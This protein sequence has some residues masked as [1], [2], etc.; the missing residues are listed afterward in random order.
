MWLLA[1][2]AFGVAQ[3]VQ[4]PSIPTA[5]PLDGG[6]QPY[7]TLPDSSPDP[8]LRRAMEEA[9]RKRNIERQAKMAAE[10]DR[11]C[12]LAQELIDELN[13][14]GSHPL[15][16]ASVKKMDEIQKLAKSVKDR[17]RSE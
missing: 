17:M 5:P 6:R 14:N 11:I 7:G 9:A 13:K 16:V 12:A 4:P 3:V 10:S 15:P 1:G 8:A 2:M